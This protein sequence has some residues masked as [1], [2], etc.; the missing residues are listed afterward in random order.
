[1]IAYKGFNWDLTCTMGKGRFQYHEGETI[2]EDRSKTASA[3]LHCAEYPFDC[4][5]YYSPGNGNRYF[6]VEAAG[7]IDED[8]HDSR[9]A[10][11]ELTLLRELTIKQMAVM[12]LAYMIQHPA[13]KWQK[14]GIC[15]EVAQERAAGD[16]E[17]AIA[18]ARGQHPRVKGAAG[19]IL[20]LLLEPEPGVFAGAR[21][22]VAGEEARPDTWYTLEG[23]V[24]KEVADHEA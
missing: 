4:F 20:G 9:I 7:S 17:G 19:C 13:R 24:L 3:G 1:M 21:I 14:H 11:T 6:E 15:L 23:N 8:D 22:V 5:D 2:R 10:C 16:G 18:I 12:G